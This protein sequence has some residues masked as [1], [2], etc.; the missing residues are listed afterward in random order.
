MESDKTTNKRH[1]DE[2]IEIVKNM[3]LFDEMKQMNYW[4]MVPVSYM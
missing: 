1:S 3:T 4:A 2:V